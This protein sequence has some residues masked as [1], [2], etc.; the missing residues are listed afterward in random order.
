MDPFK[1]Y[2]HQAICHCSLVDDRCI[3]EIGD[4]NPEAPP[5]KFRGNFLRPSFI[6][7]LFLA[8]P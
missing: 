4:G 5:K 6:A 1:N 7:Y 2:M 8:I 3:V